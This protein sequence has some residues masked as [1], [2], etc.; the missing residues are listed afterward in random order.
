MSK[1]EKLITELKLISFYWKELSEGRSEEEL[2][3]IIAEL[4]QAR[5]MIKDIFPFKVMGRD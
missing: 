1:R 5:Q 2:E 4:K 3:K